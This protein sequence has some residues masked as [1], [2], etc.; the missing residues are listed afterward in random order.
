MFV[1]DWA[2]NKVYAYDLA[3]RARD[4]TK[5]FNLAAT[6]TK[7]E[8]LWCNGDTVWVAEDDFTGSNDIFAY[9]RADGTANTDVDFPA[10][11]PNVNGSPLN[12]NPRG[13]WSNG[14]TMFVVDDEDARVYAWKMSDQTRDSAKEISL[15]AA[16]ADPEGLWFDGRVLWVI[17][18]ADDEVYAY[19]LPGAQPA[20]TRAVGTPAID[21]AA[22][23]VGVEVAAVFTG[24]TD[25]TDGLAS[26][27]IHYQWI[28]VDGSDETD[29]D[30]ETGSTYVPT[31]DD[32]GKHL[33]VRVVFDDDAGNRSIPARAPRS[34]RWWATRR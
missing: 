3:T 5:E 23:E 25:P 24:I 32:V 8:G 7:S 19:D 33:K 30:G 16:N 18:D 13:I 12:A 31:A 17:D 26:A 27:P 9:N 1:V 34:A 2:D 14:T 28:R 6:N 11:D 15:D 29:L 22:P 21:T 4:S 10:L 20:N